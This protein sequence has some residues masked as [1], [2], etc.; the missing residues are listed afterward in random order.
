LPAAPRTTGKFRLYGSDDI[1]RINFI[2]QMQGLGF[3]LQQIKHLLD[4]RDRGRYPCQEVSNLLKEKLAETRSKIRKLQVLEG[5]LA[6][7][8]QKCDREIKQRRSRPPR[9]CP[10]LTDSEGR[11]EIEML[12]EVL[13]VP[14][15]PNHGPTVKKLRKQLRSEAINAPIREIAVTD[16]AMARSLKFLGS[17]TV[18]INGRDI[19]ST[20]QQSYGLACRLYS[21]GTGV[22]PLEVLRHAIG[23]AR[24]EEG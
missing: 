10:V 12:I 24:R 23:E 7:D 17:P 5:E 14:G 9:Q 15:C 6:L 18:R 22:P 8:L 21:G 16:E 1:S 20:A 3:S 2:K 4:L 11:K 19:E 13:F